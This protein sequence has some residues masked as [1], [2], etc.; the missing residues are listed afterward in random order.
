MDELLEDLNDLFHTSRLEREAGR[1]SD[2]ALV[3]RLCARLEQ[4]RREGVL[5]GS[6][7]AASYQV[8]IVEPGQIEVRLARAPR[9]PKGLTL[10]LGAVGRIAKEDP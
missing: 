1:G 4:G 7:S 2:G 3:R 8:S 5:Y 6:T 10:R 9:S